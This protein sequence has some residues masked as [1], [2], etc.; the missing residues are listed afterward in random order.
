MSLKRRPFDKGTV[1]F[2]EV[3]LLLQVG[4][5]ATAGNLTMQKYCTL[6]NQTDL[7]DD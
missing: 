5:F 1:T 4:V 3:S 7:K 2:T 6:V